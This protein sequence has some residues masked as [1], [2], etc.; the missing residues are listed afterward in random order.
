MSNFKD[1]KRMNNMKKWL[2]RIS[3]NILG[4]IWWCEYWRCCCCTWVNSHICEHGNYLEIEMGVINVVASKWIFFNRAS[5]SQQLIFKT[6]KIMVGFLSP[7]LTQYPV[8]WVPEHGQAWHRRRSLD[9]TVSV[10]N[11]KKVH[12]Q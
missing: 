2:V 5:P 6:C 4:K 1:F 11:W 8:K 12:Q 3:Y 10:G 7:S 9:F